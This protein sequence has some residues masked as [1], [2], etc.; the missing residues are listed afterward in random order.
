VLSTRPTI[1]PPRCPCDRAGLPA[2]AEECG[3]CELDDVN[4]VPRGVTGL[5]TRTELLALPKVSLVEKIVG[6]RQDIADDAADRTDAP[7]FRPPADQRCSK[8]DRILL[9]APCG[10]ETPVE[11]YLRAADARD[12]AWAELSKAERIEA[13]QRRAAR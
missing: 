13:I 6:L 4:G 10:C 5:L 7:T 11:R 8:C 12:A 1:Q 2:G 9:S 3:L